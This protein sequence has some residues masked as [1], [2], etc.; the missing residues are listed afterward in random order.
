MA[1]EVDL[2]VSRKTTPYISFAYITYELD[3]PPAKV[4]NVGI[5]TKFAGVPIDFSYEYYDSGIKNGVGHYLTLAFG[6][7]YQSL[8]DDRGW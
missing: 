1:T 7:R 8:A 2:P 5:E 6:G 4:Y 3:A